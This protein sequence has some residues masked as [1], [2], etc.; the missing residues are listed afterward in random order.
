MKIVNAFSLNMIEEYPAIIR[1]E[2]VSE[3]WIKEQITEF[4]SYIGHPDTANLLSERLGVEISFNRATLKLKEGDQI[5]V[6][7]LIGLRKEFKELTKEE[8]QNYPIKYFLVT[9]EDITKLAK[10]L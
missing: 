6:A 3:S 4:E 9:V 5:L 8:I 2:E 7:Q 1:I 10:Y